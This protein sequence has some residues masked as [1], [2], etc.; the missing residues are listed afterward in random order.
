MRSRRTIVIGTT[1][2]LAVAGCATTNTPPAAPANPVPA[3]TL[4]VAIGG[5]P[6]DTVTADGWTVAERDLPAYVAH[7][8]AT[9]V[10]IRGVPGTPYER[11]LRIEA[12]LQQVGVHDVTIAAISR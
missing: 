10:V 11:A 5:D 2:G 1:L 8:R 12:E 4:V 9:A 7:R 6:G 3:G